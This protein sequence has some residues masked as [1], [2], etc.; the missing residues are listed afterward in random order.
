MI[1]M[2]W[3]YIYGYAKTKP[4][5]RPQLVSTKVGGTFLSPSLRAVCAVIPESSSSIP[6]GSWA[7]M[8][9]EKNIHACNHCI[10][11]SKNNSGPQRFS[12]NFH[13]FGLTWHE[14]NKTL[15][16]GTVSGQSLA[17]ANQ[18]GLNSKNKTS[19]HALNWAHPRIIHLITLPW[20]RQL[21]KMKLITCMCIY[22]YIENILFVRAFSALITLPAVRQLEQ[23]MKLY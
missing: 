23:T 2:S 4:D 20:G 21:Q 17:S 10:P 14:M 13:C 6:K 11:F 3:C 7:H 16:I 22:T 5:S 15:L 18:F 12:M 1:P 8:V 19:E 9:G